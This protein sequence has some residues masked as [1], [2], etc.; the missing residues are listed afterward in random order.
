MKVQPFAVFKRC[1]ATICRVTFEMKRS[2]CCNRDI[3]EMA[4]FA[5]LLGSSWYFVQGQ[6]KSTK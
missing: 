3:V 4:T 1:T 5:Y 2:W 6:K